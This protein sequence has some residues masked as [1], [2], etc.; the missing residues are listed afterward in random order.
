MSFGDQ[1]KINFASEVEHAVSQRKTEK[2]C[3][4]CG[5]TISKGTVCSSCQAESVMCKDIWR[6]LSR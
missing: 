3:S 1:E 5:T 4:R 6:F 2:V